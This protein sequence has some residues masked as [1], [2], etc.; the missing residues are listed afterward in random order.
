MLRPHLHLKSQIVVSFCNSS[1]RLSGEV[2]STYQAEVG[3]C[4]GLEENC[5]LAQ[6]SHFHRP[7]VAFPHTVPA[8]R[9]ARLA[10]MDQVVERASA[11]RKEDWQEELRRQAVGVEHIH[12]GGTVVAEWDIAPAG[13]L[14]GVGN[15]WSG[16]RMPD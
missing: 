5:Y 12:Q 6:H 10:R 3:R 4:A 13:Y 11:G 7:C 16:D 2:Q 9:S 14:E 8:V 1:T 15:L